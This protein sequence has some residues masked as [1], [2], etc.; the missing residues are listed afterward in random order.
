MRTGK[1][2]WVLSCYWG[3]FDV[4]LVTVPLR[5]ANFISYIKIRARITWYTIDER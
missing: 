1:Q 2:N 5:L 4:K 3:S